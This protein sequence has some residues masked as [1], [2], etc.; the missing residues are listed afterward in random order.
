MPWLV[1]SQTK[2]ETNTSHPHCNLSTGSRFQNG[3]T[4]KSSPLRTMYSVL[5]NQPTY[6][7]WY[8]SSLPARL[9]LPNSSPSILQQSLQAEP[10]STDHT[11]RYSYSMPRLW[12]S[13]P[14]ELRT[15]IDSSTPGVHSLSRQTFLSKLKTHLFRLSYPTS[16]PH[17]T[18][19][20]HT[21]SHSRPPD[22]RRRLCGCTGCTCTQKNRLSGCN[23][24]RRIQ[25]RHFLLYYFI[26]VK[27][28]LFYSCRISAYRIWYSQ[29]NTRY[30]KLKVFVYNRYVQEEILW[31]R[32]QSKTRSRCSIH[33]VSLNTWQI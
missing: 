16:T 21:V 20:T 29:V 5:P 25:E 15:P 8:H 9:A 30:F 4:T 27:M 7:N 2:E 18:N 3:S 10:S 23:A 1:L 17:T 19:N 6:P 31:N 24:P 28:K 22:H 11:G 13:L 32:W 33:Q 12:N 14:A 26:P